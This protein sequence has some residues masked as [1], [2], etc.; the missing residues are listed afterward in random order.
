VLI[1]AHFH[2]DDLLSYEAFPADFFAAGNL[3]LASCHD[4]SGFDR[5]CELTNALPPAISAARMP[6]SLPKNRLLISFG[7]H[8]QLAVFDELETL[9]SLASQGCLAAIGECGF[10]FFGDRPERVRTAINERIQCSVFETQLKL[11]HIY[12]LPLVLH[13][14]KA[15]D[16]VFRYSKQLRRLP[17]LI[18]H[19]WTGPANE[20]LAI[21][22]RCPLARFSFGTGLINGN[23]K[24]LA[25]VCRLPASALLTESDAPYQPPRA[26][27]QPGAALL[28]GWSR[29]ADVA[30]IL[31]FMA[32][33]REQAPEDLATAIYHNFLELFAS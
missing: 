4:R 21:L 32:E 1:D 9:E 19:G 14:R 12:N 7:L 17:G 20:A 24:S 25:C 10:D 33:S 5:T 23:K 18:F 13:L 22:E 27:P 15:T 28:R 3:G 26:L 16:L 29:P 8:P 31:A 11:A 30:R 2:A 6:T